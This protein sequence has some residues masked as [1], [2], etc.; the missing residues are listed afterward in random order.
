MKDFIR[1]KK[2]EE[3]ELFQTK[4]KWYRAKTRYHFYLRYLLFSDE[5]SYCDTRYGY[6]RTYEKIYRVPPDN[7]SVNLVIHL[8]FVNCSDK[9]I[10]KCKD[11]N[12][13]PLEFSEI[14]PCSDYCRWK[15]KCWTRCL[16]ICK[17]DFGWSFSV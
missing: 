8:K 1:Q 15:E 5:C 16:F 2:A 9:E 7:L 13:N 3:T 14:I 10:H 4:N 12:R 6:R 17:W 11:K